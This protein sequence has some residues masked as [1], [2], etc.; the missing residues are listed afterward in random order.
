[1]YNRPFWKRVW[2]ETE[3]SDGIWVVFE[4]ENCR[5][6]HNLLIISRLLKYSDFSKNCVWCAFLKI[7]IYLYFTDYQVFIFMLKFYAFSHRQKAASS[8]KFSFWAKI[9]FCQIKKSVFVWFKWRSLW[10]QPLILQI[11]ICRTHPLK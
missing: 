9:S 1:M 8:V 7:L 3:K 6:L 11:E 2:T 5:I 4:E 10:V